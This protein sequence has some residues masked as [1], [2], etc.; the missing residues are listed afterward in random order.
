MPVTM[1]PAAS[2]PDLAPADIDRWRAVPVAIAVDLGRDVGQIDPSIR[3]LRPAGQQPRLFGRAV[4]ALCEPPDFG[5]VLHALDLIAPGDVL[6][7]AAAGHAETAMIG[8]ILG[9]HL[10][11]RGGRGVVCD[12][13][14]RD[15]AELASWDD[16]AVF[17]RCVTPRGPS[18]AERGAVNLPVVVGGRLVAPGDLIIGDDNGLVALTPSAVR[19]RIGDAEARL[20]REAEWETSL[21]GGRSVAATFGVPPARQRGAG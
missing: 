3:P 7:I 14:V 8:E 1:H 13:A 12:G 16:F 4:T 15:V 11:R 18:S 17:A 5:A 10:R 19:G 20:A 6:L 21:A 9:G 2:V